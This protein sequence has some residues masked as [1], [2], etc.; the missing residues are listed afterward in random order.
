M[1]RRKLHLKILELIV[2]INCRFLIEIGSLLVSRRPLLLEVNLVLES[3]YRELVLGALLQGLGLQSLRHL[4]LP[5]V[6]DLN[7]TSLLGFRQPPDH[8]AHNQ[9][10]L[11]EGGRRHGH[12]E[13]ATLPE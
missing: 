13:A 9:I 6:E 11:R 12:D 8:A 3:V 7:E 1:L 5:V 4:A 10:I 2:D